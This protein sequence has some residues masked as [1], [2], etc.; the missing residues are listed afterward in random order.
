MDHS[1][2]R[3]FAPIRDHVAFYA[4]PMDGCYVDGEKVRPQPGSFYGGWLTSDIVGRAG[5]RGLVETAP[6]PDVSG[7]TCRPPT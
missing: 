1:P 3:A 5:D 4:G 2:S 6:F 7:Y